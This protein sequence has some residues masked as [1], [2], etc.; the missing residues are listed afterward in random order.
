[1]SETFNK[2]ECV[3]WLESQDSPIDGKEV[4]QN[5][6]NFPWRNIPA[7][8]TRPIVD[9][10]INHYWKTDLIRAAKGLPNHD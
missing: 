4:Q 10:R 3:E 6:P 9:G 1:M 5:F 7:G 2:K 8:I